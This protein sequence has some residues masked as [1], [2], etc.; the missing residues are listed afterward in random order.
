MANRNCGKHPIAQQS[1]LLDRSGSSVTAPGQEARFDSA[2]PQIVKDPVGCAGGSAFERVQLL[3]IL[4]VEIA[5]AP[6]RVTPDLGDMVPLLRRHSV[7]T[8]ITGDII[9][10]LSLFVLGG[11]FWHKLRALF[12]RDAK[13][14][15]PEKAAAA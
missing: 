10:L 13:V 9:L 8:G 12:I 1:P 14:V 7:S 15:F 3:H 2:A 6:I 4:D 11:N 5:D